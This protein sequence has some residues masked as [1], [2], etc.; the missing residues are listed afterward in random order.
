MAKQKNKPCRP[1]LDRFASLG[2]DCRIKICGGR[3]TVCAT[4]NRRDD[5]WLPSK[6]EDYIAFVGPQYSLIP[7]LEADRYGK[8][9]FERIFGLNSLSLNISGVSYSTNRARVCIDYSFPSDEINIDGDRW[10]AF[11]RI[12]NSIDAKSALNISVGYAHKEGPLTIQMIPPDS[13]LNLNVKHIENQANYDALL[14]LFG[15]Y[16]GYF[17]NVASNIKGKFVQLASVPVSRKAA[18]KCAVK[19]N[20]IKEEKAVG[21]GSDIIEEKASDD[22]PLFDFEEPNDKFMKAWDGITKGED[23]TGYTLAKAAMLSGAAIEDGKESSF[24]RCEQQVALS[25]NIFD[26]SI[27]DLKQLAISYLNRFI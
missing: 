17:A 14:E 23:G 12:S 16:N 4:G 18:R 26:M 11:L 9:A 25:K 6:G 19:M 20:L 3:R 21:D 22:A 13:I 8:L 2:F 10:A 1:L 7:H 5:S 27:N 24:A 15:K